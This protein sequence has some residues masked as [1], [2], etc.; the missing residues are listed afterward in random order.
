MV[1][2]AIISEYNP[3]HLGHEYQ[4][5]KIREIFGD[6]TTVIAIMS[7][8]Y[9]QRGEIA[10]ADKYLRAKCAVECGVNL[11]LELPFPYC[12]SSAEFFAKSGVKIA[13][14]L[15]NVDYLVFGSESGNIEYLSAM[16]ENMNS[17]KY[18]DQ[19]NSSIHEKGR[20]DVGYTELCIKVYEEIYNEDIS[21]IYTPNNILAIEYIKAIKS[22]NSN[23]KPYTIIR[24]GAT[25]SAENLEHGML[26]S[27][28]AIRLALAKNEL[29]AFDYVP[30]SA[31]SILSHAYEAKELPCNEEQ[32][33]S[34]V[35]CNFR[36]NSSPSS[37]GIHDV[38]GGLYNRLQG[39]SFEADSIK[40]LIALTETKK[41]TTSRIRR[42]IWYSLFGV[43]SSDMRDLPSF[44]QVL[45]LDDSGRRVLNSIRRT[46][47][48][49]ILTK[50]SAT[51][52][53]S[54]IALLAKKLSDRADSVFQLT[55][56]RAV[57]GNLSV[58]STPYVKK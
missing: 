14:S 27:A 48:I 52:K 15:Q 45:A 44:T 17:K 47:K 35:I 43:T 8:N 22:L 13:D 5:K 31:K 56:P 49:P 53:L 42:A 21:E 9:T 18:Q 2:V 20:K 36:L 25:Y 33:S 12:S 1:T 29:S 37:E 57:H 54:G 19:L 46:S 58:M 28:T 4:I 41:Y 23:I 6:D 7:G 30:N 51:D 11:V 50:P 38:G 34:A 10:F 24:E 26:P 32:I 40:S 55:K 3:F 39:A 16:A